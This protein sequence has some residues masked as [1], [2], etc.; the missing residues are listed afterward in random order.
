[1]R[2]NPSPTSFGVVL[3]LFPFERSYVFYFARGLFGHGR[4]LDHSGRSLG[5]WLGGNCLGG[6]PCM[7]L[8]LC[9]LGDGAVLLDVVAFGYQ[10]G[11][12]G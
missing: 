11:Q 7:K 3:A 2:L 1:M 4:S 10:G 12:R 8:G 5:L 6:R 9:E